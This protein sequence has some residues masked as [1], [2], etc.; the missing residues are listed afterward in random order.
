MEEREYKDKFQDLYS[1]LGWLQSG[2]TDKT[3]EA[4]RSSY[5]EGDDDSARSF[6]G[7]GSELGREIDE[8][9]DAL[10]AVE[11]RIG[12]V[13]DDWWVVDDDAEVCQTK[14]PAT[15]PQGRGNRG[16]DSQQHAHLDERGQA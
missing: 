2:V 1:F 16:H 6:M 12:K 3:L 13:L 5:D 15:Y 4:A 9:S 8:L 7:I 10:S 11:K 14:E